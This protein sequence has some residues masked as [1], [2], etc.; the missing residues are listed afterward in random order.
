V[1]AEW[2]AVAPSTRQG[3]QAPPGLEASIGTTASPGPA[4]AG[5]RSRGGRPRHLRGRITF[6]LRRSRTDRIV[7]GVAAGL[8]DRLGVDHVVVRLGFVVLAFAGGVG[9]VVY[10]LLW[11]FSPEASE[12]ADPRPTGTRGQ[13][14]ERSV[15]FAFVVGG[16]LLLLRAAGVWFGDAVVWPVALGAFG[17]ALI[18]T[19]A[20]DAGRARFARVASRARYPVEGVLTGRTSRTRLLLGSILIAGGMA[21]FLAANNA[22]VAF[23]NVVFAV[24]VTVTG[25]GLILGPW[26]WRMGRQLAEERRQRIRSEERA[27]MAAHLH[28]SV[29]QSLAL[30]QRSSSPQEMVALARGQERELRAWLYGRSGPSAHDLLSTAIEEM[31]GRVERLHHVKVEAVVVGDCRVDEPVLGLVQAAGEA[32]MNAAR[33]AG[34]ETVSVYVEVEP[35]QVTAFVR[36]QGKGF[37]PAAVPRDRRGIAE[38]ITGRME[39]AGGTAAVDSAPGEGTEV[40]L[41]LPRRTA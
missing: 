28:D 11:A 18:W 2:I 8:G 3:G 37:E 35:E 38:S 36:D 21:A 12:D 34:V 29:L 33:H 10:L 7:A 40:T 30:I 39:R 19:R 17:S 32:A 25:V 16:T 5:T 31:A 9:V 6:G 13:D 23:R 41:R 15:A 20:D 1:V 27:E 24:V 22:L 26:V 14:L 4:P